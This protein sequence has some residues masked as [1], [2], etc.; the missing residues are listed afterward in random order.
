[1]PL[2][3]SQGG[4]VEGRNRAFWDGYNKSGKTLMKRDGK[5]VKRSAKGVK[6]YAVLSDYKPQV[7]FEVHANREQAY[8]G[9]T[10]RTRAG[11]YTR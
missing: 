7:V 5:R 9:R 10:S 4:K 6:I 8:V 11:M 2:A 1:M 3:N